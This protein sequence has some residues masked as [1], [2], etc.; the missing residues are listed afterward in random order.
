MIP[1]F[2]PS[3]VRDMDKR[4]IAS[5][6]RSLTLMERAA[7][8][9]ARAVLDVAERS[10]GVRVALVCGKGNN[11]GDGIA[12]A[13][14]L[15]DAGAWPTVCLVSDP[16]ALSADAAAQLRR[17]RAIGGRMTTDV[18][19]ALAGADVVVDCLLGTGA[20]GA[21]RSPYD[22]VIEQINA[23]GV[24]VVACDLPSGVDADNGVVV[25]Q[26]V[27]ADVT[28]CLGAHKR[29]L[30]MW[31]ARACAGELRLA[32]IGIRNADD[33]PDAH[34]LE[35]TDVAAVLGEP[36]DDGDKRARG[37]VVIVAGSA[38]MSGAAV[39]SARGALAAGAGLV[40][41]ATT[42]LARHFVAPSVPEAMTVD[43]PSDDP[44][45]AFERIAA[46]CEHAGA[47]A[48]GPGIGHDTAQVRL[49]QRCI[50]ELDLP[51]VVDADGLNAF[52]A[53][54]ATLAAHKAPTLVL[55]PHRGEL[56]RIHAQDDP[57]DL[58]D[59]RIDTVPALARQ[60]RA[61]VVAKGP[62]SVIA[63]PD[64][65]V[66]V[67]STGT[68]ALATGGTGDVLTGMT[69]AALAAG[70][71]PARVAATVALHGLAGQVAAADSSM[72]S[73]TAADVASAVPRALRWAQ[74]G[75]P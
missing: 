31:P 50:A 63:A 68:A 6:T 8:H 3:R 28:L 35:A 70:T 1:L 5:G 45:T 24:R 59:R 9:L 57:D 62:G 58:W 11:G 54:A 49:V 23:C 16:A 22:T 17:W 14:H 37:V 53:D 42:T 36:S 51:T 66:W 47:L 46:A 26:A 52:R 21:P 72:R 56:A 15:R 18:S 34:L 48:I 43:L 33:R 10:Y 30:V 75:S 13:R 71:D 27:R 44:D 67:N 19:S 32:D 65:R 25:S 39:L 12:A 61:T 60:W 73:V 74:G 64:G 29:G 55:T 41:V 4:T 40:T 38:D 69:V 20:T 2:A 7:G